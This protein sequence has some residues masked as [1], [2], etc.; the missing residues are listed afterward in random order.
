MKYVVYREIN[1]RWYWELRSP[2]GSSVAKS[3]MGFANQ[4]I[5]F[6]A[7]RNHRIDAP[8]ALVFDLVGN[9]CEGI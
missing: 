1:N 6:A 2:D 7:I 5:A 8:R 3:P 9:L 4:N